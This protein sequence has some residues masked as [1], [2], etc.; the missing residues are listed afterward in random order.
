VSALV[1][2]FDEGTLELV[3]ALIACEAT[4]DLQY[5]CGVPSLFVKEG[6]LAGQH[7]SFD[8]ILVLGRGNADVV[9]DDVEISRRHA[10][11][12]AGEDFFEVVDLDSLN[13]TWVN[14]RRIHEAARVDPGDVI[15]LGKTVLEVE[16]EAELLRLQPPVA[17][18]TI[19]PGL[20]SPRTA[21]LAP[22]P[23]VVSIEEG[24]CTECGTAVPSQAR[25]C[26]Y[27][28]AALRP[29]DE[30]VLTAAPV[31]EPAIRDGAVPS[32]PA[33]DELRP[34][35]ALFA[36][37]VGSTALGERLAPDEVKALIGECVN[38]M[39]QAVEQFGG[40]IQ[41]YMGDGIAGFFGMPAAHEDDP[42]RAAHAALRIVEVVAKYAED[43]AVAWDVKDFH[44]R[45]GVNSG[46]TAVGIVGAAD[47]QK[48]ALG[49]TT[50]VAARLQSIAVPG[51]I[52][53]G[54]STARRLAHRFVLESLGEVSVKG[55]SQPV[56]AW[57]LVRVQTGTRTP[58]PTPL[59]GREPEVTRIR[60][61]LEELTEGRGQL[62][63]LV[64][65]AGIGKTR[66]LRE[67]RTIAG[68][69]TLWLDGH[70]R[71][72]GGAPLYWPFVEALR[73]WLGVD[74]GEAEV[75]VR[76]KLR[77]KLTS[78]AALDPVE[79]LPQLGRL[80]SLRADIDVTDSLREL[81]PEEL[82]EEIRRAYCT[83]IEALSTQQPVVL[84]IDDLHWADAPTR[85]LAEAL[86]AVTDR[87]P[88]LLATAFRGDLPSEGSRFRLHA[89][90]H[91][92]HRVAELALGPLSDSVAAEFLGML[93]P[94]GLDQ[95]AK[96]ELIG[97]A[98]GNPLY[99]EELLR[100]LIE[101]GVLERRRHTWALTVTPAAILP[102]ALE[103]LL[104]ARIDGLPDETGR[105]AQVAAVIG[106]VFP[107]R[108]LERVAGSE[109]CER[110]VSVLL[111]A[112]YIR[113][114]RRYPELVYTFK[115]GLLQEAA[116][117]TLTP[118]RR[119]EL[120]GR[121]AAVFEELYASSRDEYLEVL[122]YY[123][124]QSRNLAKALEYLE[125][126]GSRAA[127]LNANAQALELWTKASK[128]AAKL[129]DTAAE[130]RITEQLARLG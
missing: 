40:T 7:L 29:D 32:S 82:V 119:Q 126:A 64:G 52:L 90:E 124:A 2:A 37:V 4:L 97:R 36:D 127:S 114:L 77:A 113:E 110:G 46:Q 89:L 42:E 35:T 23:A 1:E 66:L 69:R 111:R 115:H 98:E 58:A 128:V 125:Q 104:I 92:A 91:Y 102:P 5:H 123:Y 3:A 120:Y 103:G 57:R 55:R 84:A 33:D 75:S 112:Q 61:A 85:E 20:D 41:A 74:P 8:S 24:R 26:S 67:F 44:V 31:P 60:V 79:I 88:L 71:S 122:A 99:L 12:R 83:W 15:R 93:M 18:P 116:L 73:Q 106:R 107:A 28:G 25:F 70:C 130:R 16:A 118:A 59:V 51:T 43:I 65:E 121:V 108:V 17:G 27:C 47:Q 13:G 19:E 38:R 34:V 129:K 94:E 101:G 80:L 10:L 6:P 96:Q 21:P 49:D 68:D 109:E 63:L 78:L 100:S 39:A 53:V 30:G 48:V 87:A 117:S 86:L 45:V 81:R 50:N 95:S 54:E 76:T 14:G 22:L 72:Y 56:A 11:I 9:I 62:L 105:L